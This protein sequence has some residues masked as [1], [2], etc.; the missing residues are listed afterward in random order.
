MHL[1][2]S[3]SLHLMQPNLYAPNLPP[4]RHSEHIVT[5][6]PRMFETS[7]FTPVS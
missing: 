1:S 3:I 6:P 2:L 5:A 7:G 4:K